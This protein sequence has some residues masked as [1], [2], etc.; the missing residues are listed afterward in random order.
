MV[1]CSLS[2]NI[3]LIITSCLVFNSIFTMK[4][5]QDLEEQFFKAIR[6]C[7]HE[8]VKKLIKLGVDLNT[9]CLHGDSPLSE[10]VWFADI[11]MLEILIAAGCDIN[12]QELDGGSPLIS[13]I[14]S[15]NID[16]AR[17]LIDNGAKT[18]FKDSRFQDNAFVLAAFYGCKEIVELLI[19]RAEDLNQIDEIGSTALITASSW[20][21]NGIV[22]ILIKNGA[23]I[24]IKKSDGHT[25][26]TKAAE[27]GNYEIVL[28]LILAGADINTKTISQNTPLILAAKKNYYRTVE[29]LLSYDAD[30]N[31]TNIYNESALSIGK[32]FVIVKALIEA[33]A[34]LYKESLFNSILSCDYKS[35]VKYLKKIGSVLVKDKDKNT[36]L[37][38]AVNSYSQNLSENYK[39]QVI[40]IFKVIFFLSPQLLNEK[41]NIGITSLELIIL[42]G[43]YD[44]LNILLDLSYTKSVVVK[45]SRKRKRD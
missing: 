18:F 22:K 12:R 13:A 14:R 42:T 38:L 44:L 24:N 40:R 25:A 28:D 32:N 21:Y 23:D 45:K 29:L 41:N 10:A 33:K 26:L 4:K 31:I 9:T 37:H 36:L 39:E 16:I 17:F 5:K 1:Y 30:I 43:K 19:S 27:A 8:T 2:K 15:S 7:D 6:Q 35:F 11:E 34:R 3:F 20:D